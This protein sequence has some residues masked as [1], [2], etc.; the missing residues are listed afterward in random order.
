MDWQNAADS[1]RTRRSEHMFEETA[2]VHMQARE[3]EMSLP[4][5]AH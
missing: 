2:H 3:D 1:L 4:V 5:S